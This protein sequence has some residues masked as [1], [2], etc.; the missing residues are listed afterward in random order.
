MIDNAMSI[1]CKYAEGKGI[2]N[3]VR[4]LDL[5]MCFPIFEW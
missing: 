1:I 3:I 2:A 4:E 5:V